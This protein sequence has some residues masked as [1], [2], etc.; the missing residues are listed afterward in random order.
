M[1]GAHRVL[2]LSGVR[3]FCEGLALRLSEHKQLSVVGFA[4]SLHDA[5]EQMRTLRPDVVLVDASAQD[6]LRIVSSLRELCN[7]VIIA[8]AVGDEETEAIACAEVGVNA[9][10]ERDASVE[11][12]VRAIT[13]CTRGE[14]TLS[15]RLVGALFRRVGFLARMASGA[16][17]TALT[18]RE[19]QIYSLLRQGFANKDIASRLGISL[20]TVKNHVR[21]VL[22]KLGV[23]RR[24]EAAALPRT[25]PSLP[26]TSRTS[27]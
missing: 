27:M 23:H 11:D 12:L 8:F 14:M 15:P 16:P 17:A 20:P 1:S 3:L 21:R 7:A 26:M 2:I 19:A 13:E 24:S 5:H 6:F 25:G 10:I 18:L 9:F 4:T 22:E